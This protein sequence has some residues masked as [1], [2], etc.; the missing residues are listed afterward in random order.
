MGAGLSGGGPGRDKENPLPSLSTK[1]KLAPCPPPETK[2]L[3]PV[4][5]VPPPA[6]RS[7]LGG[8]SAQVGADEAFEFSDEEDDDDIESSAQE[9]TKAANIDFSKIDYR[10]ADLNKLGDSELKAHK[11]SMEVGFQKNAVKKGD[12]GFEYDKR[13][14]FKYKADEALDNSWDE[15]D[16]SEDQ[17]VE[18]VPNQQQQ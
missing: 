18:I 10:K 16:D 15:S 13:V 9:E 4:S 17:G 14:N 8:T 5:K 12:A 6:Q 2:K 7:V 1:S 11:A 3:A